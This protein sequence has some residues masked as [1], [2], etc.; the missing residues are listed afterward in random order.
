MRFKMTDFILG[1]IILLFIVQM[2]INVALFCLF[3][4]GF[5]H[6]KR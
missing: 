2:G 6:V 4:G 5:D 1:F 3:L